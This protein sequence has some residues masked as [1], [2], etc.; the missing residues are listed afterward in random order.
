M[1][2]DIIWHRTL[3]YG[4]FLFYWYLLEKGVFIKSCCKWDQRN[5]ICFWYCLKGQRKDCMKLNFLTYFFS[6]C[7][8]RSHVK[9]PNYFF[10]SN[11]L[12]YCVL[13]VH[14]WPVGIW[15]VL[16]LSR[17]VVSSVELLLWCWLHDELFT[18]TAIFQLVQTFY[19]HTQVKDEAR[20]KIV[21]WDIGSIFCLLFCLASLVVI[22]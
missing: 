9:V 3:L 11:A 12:F 21:S 15:F 8:K 5:V 6:R 18:T 1:S 4:G 14:C 10:N 7:C 19:N 22:L 13:L 2:F 20:N 17:A 16:S